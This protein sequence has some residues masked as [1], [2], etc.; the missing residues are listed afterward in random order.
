MRTIKGLLLFG[1]VVGSQL[2]AEIVVQ[3]AE[4][5]SDVSFA[6]GTVDLGRAAENGE[7]FVVY[8]GLPHHFEKELVEKEIRTKTTVRFDGNWFYTPAQSTT[9]EEAAHLTKLFG[10]QV[11]KPW[12]GFKFCGGFHGDYAVAFAS[13]KD[14]WLVLFCFSCHEARI[15]KLP[16]PQGTQ[17]ASVGWRLTVDLID[18]K[19]QELTTLFK[20][21]R[22]ERPASQLGKPKVTA[23]A[24]AP[25]PPRMPVHI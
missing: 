14:N 12:R 16:M 17:P 3:Q 25:E 2:R 9:E 20:N 8:E 7:N 18:D 19:F 10:D 21:R 11:F 13:G 4:G 5:D 23:P 1:L 6:Q 22:Q 15:L 24:P